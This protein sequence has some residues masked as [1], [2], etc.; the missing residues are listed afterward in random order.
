L[1]DA[2]KRAETI[3]SDAVVKALESTRIET[4]LARN[5]AF[6]SSHDVMMS[7]VGPKMIN[8]GYI[9]PCLFQWQN[10]KQVPVYPRE[11]ME[12]TGA[13]FEFPPWSGPW[14]D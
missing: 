12:E 13:I 2:I 4:S 10:A 11:I 6:T 3:D 5:F 8:E 14:S 9:L 1:P 7:A